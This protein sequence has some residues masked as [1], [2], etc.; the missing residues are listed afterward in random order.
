MLGITTLVAGVFSIVG[1]AARGQAWAIG[2]SLGMGGIAVA[3]A[4]YAA[5]FGILWVFSVV[6]SPLLNRPLRA[7]KTTLAGT[8]SPFA[9]PARAVA[10]EVP[11][12]A[13]VAD[14][15]ERAAGGAGDSVG[16]GL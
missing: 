13:I 4:T 8:S 10:A 6:V 1:L 2:V 14:D 11:V 5:F 12:E 7:G 15:S 3:L 16:E 9:G